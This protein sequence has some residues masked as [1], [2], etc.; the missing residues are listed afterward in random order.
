MT[1]IIDRRKVLR[2]G[3]S[4]AALGLLAGCDTLSF[5]PDLGGDA[6]AGGAGGTGGTVGPAPVRG[7]AGARTFG[8]GPVKVALLLPLTGDAAPVGISMA[9]AAQLAMDYVAASPKIGDNITLVVM[10]T[11][12]TAQGASQ[13]ASEALAAGVKL[14]LGPLKADQVEAAGAVAKAAGVPLIGFS[15]NS[16]AAEPG[17]YLLNVLPESEIHRSLSY[18]TGRGRKAIA[19]VFPTTDFGRVQQAAFQIVAAGL[20]I[21]PRSV[22]SYGSDTDQRSIASTLGPQINRGMVDAV[23]MPDRA[24]APGFAKLLRTAGAPPGK[25]LLIGSADWDTDPAILAASPLAGAVYPAIDDTGYLALKADYQAKFGGSPHPLAT[26]AYTA[27]I[28]ANAA[29]L[30]KSKPPYTSAELT[31]PGGFSG[32][33]G[34]FRFLPDG[35]SQY[36]LIMK[37]VASS[38]AI[39]VDAAKL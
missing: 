18:A 25:A 4:L 39:K 38:G 28:L 14:I 19:A 7:T 24:G 32:R 15:N 37:Q 22:F 12:P 29:P 20:G 27:A 35:R 31:T 3:G 1:I 13:R 30:A 21:A 23:F 2:L 8:S 6:G 17:V 34:V 11:G 10:D 33:D 5:G 16:A 9:N 36:A 26:I